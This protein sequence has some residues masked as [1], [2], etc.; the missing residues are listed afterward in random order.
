MFLRG[1]SW[2]SLKKR[3]ATAAHDDI[4]SVVKMCSENQT[5]LLVYRFSQNCE[6]TC[7]EKTILSEVLLYKL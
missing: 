6:S 4:D 5:I 1:T 2:P 3:V 7:F